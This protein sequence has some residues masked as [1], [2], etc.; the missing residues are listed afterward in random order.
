M[1]RRSARNVYFGILSVARGLA[2][3]KAFSDPAELSSAA[4]RLVRFHASYLRY[5][6]S[7]KIYGLLLLE[8]PFGAPVTC[9]VPLA[10]RSG[11]RSHRPSRGGGAELW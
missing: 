9:G 1:S 6:L 3:A 8:Y 2:V 7:P 5:K 4:C 10:H 11:R